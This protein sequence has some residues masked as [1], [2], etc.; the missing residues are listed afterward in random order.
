MNKRQGFSPLM[1][2]S[3]P[4]ISMFM[5]VVFL[6]NYFRMSYVKSFAIG[7]VLPMTQIC[8]YI[9]KNRDPSYQE[10]YSQEEMA[11]VRAYLGQNEAKYSK[12]LKKY[13]E[14]KVIGY[15]MNENQEK[16]AYI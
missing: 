13:Y 2:T 7:V 14:F 5:T 6:K 15:V 4:E 1:R 9:L 16:E 12:Y 8:Q 3:L 11:F 10:Y